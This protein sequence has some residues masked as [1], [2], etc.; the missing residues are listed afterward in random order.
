MA[1][2]KTIGPLTNARL[3]TVFLWTRDFDRMRAFYRDTLGL[4]V[5]YQ[6]P[7][8]AMFAGGRCEIALHEE[9]EPHARSDSWHMEFLVDDIESVVAELAHR[10]V[11]VS[12]IRQEQFGRIATFQDPEGNVIGLEEPPKRTS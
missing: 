4:P 5:G 8:F 11:A 1:R 9:R 10:G 6:N 3:E 2:T 7:H 12:P